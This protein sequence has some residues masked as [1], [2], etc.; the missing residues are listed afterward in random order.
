MAITPQTDLRLLKVNI[1]IDERNQLTFTDKQS[2]YIDFV[3][4]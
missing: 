2:N 3:Y 4:L 1:N